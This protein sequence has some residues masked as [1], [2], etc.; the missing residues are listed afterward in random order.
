MQ[1][2]KDI[3]EKIIKTKS[4]YKIKDSTELATKILMLLENEKIRK[5]TIKNFKELCFRESEK[6]YSIIKNMV[7]L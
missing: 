2:F 4:G 5:K 1:N 3:E 7:N 6:A